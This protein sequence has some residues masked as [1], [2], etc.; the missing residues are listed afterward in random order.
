MGVL[1]ACLTTGKGSWKAVSDVIDSAEWKK[2]YLVTND[3][4][5]E[6]FSHQ[7]EIVYV[8][9]DL[10]ESVIVMRDKIINDLANLRSEIGFNDVAVNFSSGTGKEHAAVL[11]AILKLGTGVR[12][13]DSKNKELINL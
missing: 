4:G 9:V 1:V 5:K 12:V 6:K 2:I 11:S 8:V 3:F 10:K 13:V 7:K